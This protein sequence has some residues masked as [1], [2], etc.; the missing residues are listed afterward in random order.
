MNKFVSRILL[1]LS[2]L[3]VCPGCLKKKETTSESVS[4]QETTRNEQEQSKTVESAKEII[5]IQNEAQ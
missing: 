4:Y 2:A 3:V 5:D 1:S